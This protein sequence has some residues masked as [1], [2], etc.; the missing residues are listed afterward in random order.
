[1]MDTRRFCQSCLGF[2]VWTLDKNI[3]HSY[4][5]MC[6]KRFGMSNIKHI[7]TYLAQEYSRQV[8]RLFEEYGKKI[9]EVND[10]EKVQNL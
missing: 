1:M 10:M 2:T 9:G 7:R 8:M 3:N 5:R 6:G 4:C